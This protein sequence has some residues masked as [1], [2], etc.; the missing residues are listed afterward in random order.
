MMDNWTA[1]N[2][3]VLSENRKLTLRVQIGNA[4]EEVNKIRKLRKQGSFGM[5]GTAEG[6]SRA[7]TEARR[8]IRAARKELECT[9]R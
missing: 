2:Q 8:K 5:Y 9:S 1:L 3:R 4:Q 7:E 6:R